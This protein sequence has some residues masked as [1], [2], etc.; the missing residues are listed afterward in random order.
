VPHADPADHLLA[1]GRR[2]ETRD[3]CD[4]PTACFLQ[5]S[6]CIHSNTFR[7]FVF[8]AQIELLIFRLL[9]GR[10]IPAIGVG[11]ACCEIELTGRGESAGDFVVLEFDI[12]SRVTLLEIDV[13]EVAHDL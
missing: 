7:Q 8:R 6:D 1:V 12:L 13:S 4:R 10:V 3:L 11:V 9:I 2:I 5:C